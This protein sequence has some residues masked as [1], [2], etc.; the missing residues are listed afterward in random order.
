MDK[1][2]E[3]KVLESLPNF[4][5]AK[6]L[7]EKIAKTVEPLMTRRN[8][9]VKI[10]KEFFPKNKGLLGM[11]VNRGASILIRLRKPENNKVFFEWEH[12]IGTMIH[13]LTHME[14]GPHSADFYKL[15]DAIHDEVDN[16]YLSN[17]NFIT[18]KSSFSDTYYKLG[19]TIVK[20]Q[21]KEILSNLALQAANKRIQLSALMNGSGK[22]LGSDNYSLLSKAERRSLAAK[23]AQRRIEDDKKLLQC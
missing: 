8:W 10:L 7:L 19:G 23:A 11:N 3:I 13:E 6:L 21:N 15:M 4:G 18:K 2:C 22:K 17:L 9:K 1:V 12:L 5:E 16:D 20:N 14:I